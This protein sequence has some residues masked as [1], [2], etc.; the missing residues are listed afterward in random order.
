[1]VSSM[2][3]AGDTGSLTKMTT[4]YCDYKQERRILQVTG[5]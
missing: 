5:E 1:L 3:L 4:R 2:Y